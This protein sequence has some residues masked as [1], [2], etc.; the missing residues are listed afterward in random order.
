MEDHNYI[1]D[2]TEIKNIMNRSSRFISLSGLSGVLAG[3][4]ALIG[5]Y[6]SKN[7]IDTYNNTSKFISTNR[8]YNYG[9]PHSALQVLELKLKIIAAL[10]II[11]A[12]ITGIVLTVYKAKKNN[13][14][15]W[16]V[17]SKRLLFNFL[18]PLVTG[19]LFSLVLLEKGYIGLLAS[20][21]LIFYG[22]ACINASKYT[23]GDIKYLG[24][25][26]VIL[27]LI[28]TQYIGYGLYFWAF[29]FGIMHI[30]YGIV[31]YLKY[32]RK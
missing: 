12:I 17:S 6:I 27:G 19:G 2:I 7:M 14:K 31:M 30:F 26:N 25:V 22:M 8:N 9:Q 5:A 15:V 20:S 1:K 16:D 28:A 18:F 32:D 10:V 29:G 24:M 13:A 11:A 21:T 23:F 3:V 4:Y